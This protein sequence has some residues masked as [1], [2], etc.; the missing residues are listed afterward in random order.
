MQKLNGALA[1]FLILSLL[2]CSTRALALEPNL[3]PS[4]S[5]SC[6]NREQKEQI[7]VCF[8]ENLACHQALYGVQSSPRPSWEFVALGIAAGM[9][10]GMILNSQ[11]HH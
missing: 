11:L 10:T 9:V 7:E 6:L 3:Q 4:N 5:L 1:L 2:L 8:E